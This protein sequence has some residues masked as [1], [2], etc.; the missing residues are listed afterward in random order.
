M[1]CLC[2]RDLVVL[3]V[4][5]IATMSLSWVDVKALR[6]VFVAYNALKDFFGGVV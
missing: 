2:L 4:G 1:R 5:E 6:Q 3:L